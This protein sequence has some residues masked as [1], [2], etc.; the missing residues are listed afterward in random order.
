M[1]RELYFY[2][3]KKT[4]DGVYESLI[5][6]KQGKPQ[7]IFW[8]SQS[9]IDMDFFT[10]EL[11]MIPNDVLSKSDF[12]ELANQYSWS[13]SEE[14]KSYVYEL[15]INKLVK[16][17]TDGIVEGY[18]P[19]E[20]VIAYYECEDKQEY[21]YWEMSKPISPYVFLELS[22]DEKKDYMR[23]FAVDT[24]SIGYVCS[25]LLEILMDIDPVSND[26]LCY[27]VEYSF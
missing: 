14:S 10:E 7:D 3:A 17:N 24:Y 19:K 20:E 22:D 12:S 15:D 21:L 8:R 9:F 11:P 27:V 23:F 1:S 16:N 4:K 2:P 6:N 25:H 26:E 13:D 18:C 5:Y